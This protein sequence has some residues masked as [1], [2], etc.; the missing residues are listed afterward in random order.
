[1]SPTTC[2]PRHPPPPRHPPHAR[3]VIAILSMRGQGRKSD[4]QRSLCHC[5]STHTGTRAKAW[6][7]LVHAE[8][9]S[10]AIY[11]SAN[12]SLDRS[13]EVFRRLVQRRKPATGFKPSLRHSSVPE[14][15][16]VIG[17][18]SDL[19]GFDW[20]DVFERCAP[21]MFVNMYGP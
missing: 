17:R 6:Y 1:M 9:S 7:V 16:H 12:H 8:S 14:A 21:I 15:P 10:L 11:L 20:L 2:T 4:E 3:H 19:L 18:E 13:Y 5:H